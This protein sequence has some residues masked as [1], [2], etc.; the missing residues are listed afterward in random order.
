[1]KP[2]LEAI[3]PVLA[4]RDV[5]VSAQFYLRLG[6]VLAFQDQPTEPKYAVMQRDGV[7]LHLQWA[8]PDQWAHPIDRPVYRF[9]VSGVDALYAEF[10]DAGVGGADTSLSGPWAAPQDTPWGTRE[11]HVRDPGQNSLQFYQARGARA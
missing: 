3:H 2:N 6:F 9:M 5:A 1:M 7:E 11:F 10:V 8:D 4:A